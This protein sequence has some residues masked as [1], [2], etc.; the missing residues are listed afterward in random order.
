MIHAAAENGATYAKI[1]SIWANDLTRRERFEEGKTTPQGLVETIKRP[2]QLEYERLKP[3]EL[4]LEDHQWFIEECQRRGL[5][6][7]TTLFTRGTVDAVAALP[8]PKRLVKIASYDC[9]SYA[10]LSDLKRHFDTFFVSTGA[11]HDEEIARTAEFLKEKHVVF[12]HCVTRYP[13]TFDNCHLARLDFLRQFSAAVGWSDHTRVSVDGIK[14]SKAALALGADYIE[15]HFTILPAEQTKD[16]PISIG[17]THVKK[18]AEFAALSPDDRL[19][20]AHDSIPEF[21]RLIGQRTRA[22]TH[23]EL[24]NRDYYRGRFATHIEGRPRYNWIP[25]EKS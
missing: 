22:L 6:P 13:N 3:L 9:A 24:L 18:L 14:A 16:G 19:R 7:F 5:I 21:T 10:L 4:S 20:E 1:Q 11:T 23:E 15:R 2:Y 17:P 25:E 8:W 12:F